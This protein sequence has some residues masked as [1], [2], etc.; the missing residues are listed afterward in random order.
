[1]LIETDQFLLEWIVGRQ[2][3]DSIIKH[4]LRIKQVLLPSGKESGAFSEGN[5]VGLSSYSLR[6]VLY[7]ERL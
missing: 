1:M 4:R 3:V 7:K 6:I 2:Y 5:S